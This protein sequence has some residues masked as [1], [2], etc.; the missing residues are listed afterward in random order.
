LESVLPV[1]EQI[2]TLEFEVGPDAVPRPKQAHGRTF[3]NTSSTA[4]ATLAPDRLSLETTAYTSFAEFREQ[5][6]TCC[7]AIVEAGVTPALRRIGLRYIDE[8]R[9]QDGAVGDA[10]EWGTWITPPLI[11]QLALGPADAAV[12]QAEGVITYRLDGSRGLNFR[13]AAL[14]QGAVVSPIT[15]LRKPFDASKP[16]FVLDLDGYQEF[17]SPDAT[18]L[19]VEVVADAL[20]AV[21]GPSGATFQASI[22][23]AARELFRRSDG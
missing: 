8:I 15:L 18:M 19:S 4:V 3:K 16:V 9:V 6:L 23:D 2:Q 11:G 22:T 17:L 21:H 1:Q 5:M 14:A 12:P 13:F 20:D 7:R 10:R